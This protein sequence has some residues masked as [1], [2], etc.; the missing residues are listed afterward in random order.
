MTKYVWDFGEAGDTAD[1]N[2]HILDLPLMMVVHSPSVATVP[3]DNPLTITATTYPGSPDISIPIYQPVLG[4][5]L[6]FFFRQLT[7][8]SG[9]DTW[10]KC[11][12]VDG[13]SN[14][15]QLF[16][17]HISLTSGFGTNAQQ[18]PHILSPDLT[19]LTNC[20]DVTNESITLEFFM[21][22][23]S[24]DM[25]FSQLGILSGTSGTLADY[26]FPP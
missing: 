6:V 3:G 16:E 7:G 24:D 2:A 5:R 15:D 10:V 14:R 4:T 13:S 17:N 26:G 23:A 20:G 9:V 19:S 11:D 21:K 25:T 18:H 12:C 1:F 8:A 22:V